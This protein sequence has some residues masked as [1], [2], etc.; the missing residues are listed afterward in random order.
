M[1]VLLDEHQLPHPLGIEIDP[2]FVRGA[3]PKMHVPTHPYASID[4]G[5]A[6]PIGRLVMETMLGRLLFA[7]QELVV[8][9]DGD[10]S[11]CRRDNLS[12]HGPWPAHYTE[13]PTRAL[14]PIRF[15]RE[16]KK[17]SR[18]WLVTRKFAARRMDCHVRIIQQAIEAYDVRWVEARRGPKTPILKQRQARQ[19]AKYDSYDP[20]YRSWLFRMGEAPFRG[21]SSQRSLREP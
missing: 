14:F 17:M 10:P 19:L 13:R 6:S 4:N 15:M 12:Y 20:G 11:N 16:I 2:T 5:P 9:L 8:Y 1:D 7:R 21:Q 3:T 18:D